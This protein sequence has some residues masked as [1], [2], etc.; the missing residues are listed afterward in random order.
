MRIDRISIFLAAV[1][2][3]GVLASLD[4][5]AA[6][7]GGLESAQINLSDTGSLRRGAKYYMNYCAG[8]HSLSYVRYG[9]LARDLELTDEQM[10]ENLVFASDPVN[11]ADKVKIGSTIDIAMRA[12][13][14]E[15]WFGKT[16]PDLTMTARYK[17][18]GPDWIYTF[19]KSFYVDPSR[20]V[21]WNN[22]L[23]AGA[24]MPHVLWEL[25]GI[26]HLV[27]DHSGSGHAGSDGGSGS[28]GAGPTSSG[29]TALKL[30]TPGRLSAEEYNQVIRDLSN[31]LTYA[32]EPAAL[33]RERWGVWVMLYLLLLC[34]VLYLLKQEYWRDI[35]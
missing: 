30:V 16:P 1:V 23:F 17:H 2:G 9:R 11:P 22:K 32:A 31:F 25:Q 26:Q 13:D 27:A 4:A 12:E 18:G 8:C 15:A 3:V 29:G 33:Q 7:G 14:G 20:P 28:A 21:G 24:S 19:L 10:L 6:G 5:R 34:G 35:H